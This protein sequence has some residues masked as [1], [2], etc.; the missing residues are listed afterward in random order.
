MANTKSALKRIRSSARKREHNH[1]F[2]VRARTFVK[3]TR[4]L[5]AEGR[6][7]EARVAAMQA[8]KTLDKAAIKGVIHPNNASRR[9]SRLMRMLA[10]AEREAQ[11]E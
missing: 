1:V 2:R 8:V 4:K 5:V 6:L 9:K 10:A 7:D 11:A 3:K